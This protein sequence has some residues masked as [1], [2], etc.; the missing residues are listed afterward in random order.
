VFGSP[1]IKIID[2]SYGKITEVLGYVG[3]LFGLVVAFFA[4]FVSSY[5]KLRY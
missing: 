1:N 4:I 3:G 2:R 5:N